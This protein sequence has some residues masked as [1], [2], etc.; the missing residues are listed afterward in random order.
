MGTAQMKSKNGVYVS[1]ID[2]IDK[3]EWHEIIQRFD[4]AC[5]HQTWS[6]GAAR[7]GQNNL[8]HLVLKRNGEI[9]AAAQ[10]ALS[11][12]PVIG[13]GI[14][15]IKFGPMWQL[16][17]R[18]KDLETYCQI[19]CA[20]R[21]EYAERRGLLL[22]LKPWEAEGNDAEMRSLREAC[23][24][25][26]QR[27]L[28]HYRTFI[29]DMSYTATE[30]YKGLK[31]KWRYTLRRA[32]KQELEIRQIQGKEAVDIFM[33]LYAE[34]RD[35]KRFFDVSEINILRDF[36]TDL[37]DQLKPQ[38]LIGQ[39]RDNPVAGLVISLIG[40][41]AF[42]LFAATGEKGLESGA[43]Y[44]LQWRAVNWLKEQGCR[45]YDLVG[46]HSDRGSAGQSE[47]IHRFK[48]GLKG[49][50]GREVHMGDFDACCSWPSLITVKL[51]TALRSTYRNTRH[52][53]NAWRR[54]ARVRLK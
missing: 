54:S 11:R 15:H 43:S 10:V 16:R 20:L 37:P 12:L 30:L 6:F 49:R 9:I 39:L 13:M 45:W 21:E 47:G 24:L 31:P 46:A 7:W 41:T 52:R 32:Q 4:D 29:L 22:R 38:I 42:C 18:E 40:K 5:I 19:I 50:Y 48:A 8:S 2:K 33:G 53:L 25:Q 14:A 44:V 51:A 35:R 23:G 36:Y 27:H 28:P 3:D 34:M 1:E 17:G 26:W